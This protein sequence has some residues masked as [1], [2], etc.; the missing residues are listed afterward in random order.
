M[1]QELI[2]RSEDLARLDAAYPVRIV[3]PSFFVIDGICYVTS[4]G[5]VG[6][7][8]LIMVLTLQGDVTTKPI[9]HVIYWTGEYPRRADLQVLETLGGGNTNLAPFGDVVMFSARADY[10][11]HHHKATTYIEIINR[12]VRKRNRHG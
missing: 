12:E 2:A 10:T 5:R 8:S 1:S 6:E 7:A 11:D 4:S 9:D 3:E